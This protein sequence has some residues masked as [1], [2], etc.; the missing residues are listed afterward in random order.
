MKLVSS[1]KQTTSARLGRVWSVPPCS[2]VINGCVDGYGV[3]RIGNGPSAFT[4]VFGHR[5][6][7][8]GR[9]RISC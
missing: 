6:L 5:Q 7:G 8:V 2:R 3:G 9:L 1:G 4:A